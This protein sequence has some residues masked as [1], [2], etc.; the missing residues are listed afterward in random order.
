MSDQRNP[1]ATARAEDGTYH[2]ADLG[3]PEVAPSCLKC[4][5][6]ACKHDD[7][8]AFRIWLRERG[9]K[10]EVKEDLL[11]GD[12]VEDIAVRYG[13]TIRTVFRINSEVN[14]P[15]PTGRPRKT[16]KENIHGTNVKR[17]Q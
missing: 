10:M 16:T 6:A 8:E 2:Y 1:H 12:R 14:G 7:P 3:C 13:V 15:R 5:L 17:T 9:Y 4:P 11:K